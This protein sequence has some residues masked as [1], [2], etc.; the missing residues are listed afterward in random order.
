MTSGTVQKEMTYGVPQGSMLGPLQ[1]NIAFDD[2]LK[3]EVPSGV[4]I[5]CDA[6]D[7]LVVTAENDIPT[8]ERKVNT[9]LEAMTRWI[10]LA[11]LNLATTNTE[12]V[13]FTRHCQ[14]SPPSFRLKG[15]QIRHCTALKYLGL[16]FDGKLTCKEHTKRTAAKPETTIA[17][18]SRLMSNLRGPSEG[19]SK[20]L[21]NVVMSLLPYRRPNL[22]RHHQHQ[23][24]R[25]T[26][27]VLVQ[28]KA[29]LRCV[30]AY[31]T[32][33]I[34]AGCVLAGI[35]PIEIVLD[36]S[37]R[38]YSA[39]HRIKPKSAKVLRVRREERQVTLHK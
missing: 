18:I 35:P 34:E 22:V 31:R 27:M 14:F 16:W 8:P 30:S 11:G 2:I 20:L 17:S 25:R 39:T 32:I 19:K 15:E 9:T 21:V 26:E 1:W 23:T 29:A 37:R 38:V 36:K 12:V 13:L 10:E 33:F 4:N 24:Y 7:T 5:I 28:R 3:E 6:D